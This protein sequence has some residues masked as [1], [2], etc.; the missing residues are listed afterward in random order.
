MGAGYKLISWNRHK[1]IYDIVVVFVILL[2][3]FSYIFVGLA[4]DKN[5]NLII[6]R[7]RALGSVTFMLLTFILLI[8]PLTR[9][10]PRFFPILYNRRHL[11]VITFFVAFFHARYVVMEYH[12]WGKLEPIFNIF[13]GNTNYTL[14][15]QFPFQTLGVGALFIMFLMAFTSHDFWL[16]NLTPRIWKFLHVCVY[17]SYTLVVLHVFLGPLQ[18]ESDPFLISVTLVSIALVVGLHL[19]TGLN[20]IKQDSRVTDSVEGFIKVC[21]PSEIPEGQARIANLAHERVAVFKHKSEIYAISNVCSHQNGPLGEGRI[22]DGCVTC[23]WHGYQFNLK[24]GKSPPPFEDKVDT[25]EVR[26]MDGHVYV[27][28]APNLVKV[29]ESGI[30]TERGN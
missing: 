28:E 22:I 20:E 19:I 2:Y 15:T 25:Y 12:E 8:G 3:V 27:S 9:L 30:P 5:S 18:F 14:L 21:L 16:K 10:S 1:V 4:L 13:L 24:D 11:G 6:L 26:L 29:I 17:V 7:M 23:P